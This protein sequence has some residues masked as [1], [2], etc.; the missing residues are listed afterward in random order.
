MSVLC[1]TLPNSTAAESLSVSTFITVLEEWNKVFPREA[2]HF[3]QLGRGDLTLSRHAGLE[4][5]QQLAHRL[6]AVEPRLLH[7]YDAFLPLQVSQN[8][9]CVR[10]VAL[11]ELTD[12][13]RLATRR[14]QLHQK[15]VCDFLL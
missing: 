9:H 12:R 10:P 3:F 14:G 8:G 7:L 5:S 13:R 2:Q 6:G 11:L 4:P 1:F 15:L